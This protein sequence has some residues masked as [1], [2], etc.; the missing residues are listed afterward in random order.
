MA[1]EV[2]NQRY[3]SAK[4]A[5][6]DT[7]Y[8]RMNSCQRDA[9]YTVNGPLLVLAGAGSGKTTVLVNRISH[10]IRYGN[11]Y[12]SESVPSDI[13]EAEI[14]R[15]EAM[16]SLD[17]EALA[18]ALS[19]FADAPCPPWAVLAITFT[20]KAAGEIKERLE[21]V[22]GDPDAA[23]EI[24]AGTFHSICVRILRRYAQ[25][26]GYES[27]FTIYDT[28]DTKKLITSCMK[29]LGIDEKVIAP[30]AAMSVISRAKDKLMT[31]KEFSAEAA[32]DFKLSRIAQIYLE[33]ERELKSANALDFDDII[34]QTVLLLMAN[35]EVR[36]YYQNRFRYVCVDE[37][38]DT[39]I[40]QLKLCEL[41]SAKR[42]NIMV[43]GD[44]DQSIY[45][46][47]GATIENILTFDRAFSDCKVI[48]L[49][50]NYRSTA[51][52]LNAANAVIANNKG[53][54]GKSLW[55]D[56]GDGDK[57]TV[58]QLPNQNIEAQYVAD[59]ILESVRRDG[60]RFS[61]FAVLYRMN[62]QSAPLESVFTK[63]GI[64][65]RMLGGLRFFDRKEIKDIVAYLCVISNS[66]DS[67][68]LK[69]I[70]NEPKRKIG[71]STVGA[72][73]ALAAIENT[74]LYDI[75]KRSNQYMQLTK[76]CDRLLAFTD[77]IDRMRSLSQ[78]VTI[79]EL[80]NT[81]V[82]ESGYH[83]MLLEEGET[84]IE[85]LRN[86]DE[87]IAS[88]ASYDE[89]AD[90]P[91]LSGFLEEVALVSDTDNYD[92][93][94][95]AV[96]MMTIHSAKGLEF[97]TVFLPGLEEGI[98]PGT[99]SIGNDEEIEEERRLAYVAITRAKKKLYILNA[100]ERMMFGKTRY[101]PPSCFLTEIPPQYINNETEGSREP[102]NIMHTRYKPELSKEM[103]TPVTSSSPIKRTPLEIFS[104][105][106]RVVHA[107][108]G[109][110]TR[111][112][113][114]KM[115]DDTLYE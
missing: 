25:L 48:K 84:G 37:F 96:V 52:I 36:T 77:F 110:G 113:V 62:S 28:D 19:E 57:I 32:S 29:R 10:I 105:G 112:S 99:M 44:D 41:I 111:L 75:M 6:F 81:V 68:R 11:A 46:F 60:L 64:P 4:R 115:G 7:Y 8:N 114:K 51:N 109:E 2:L 101:N 20:N 21:K 63:S 55:T 43:V 34:M 93:Q 26:A 13:T 39:N 78:A 40:A 94:A 17:S 5:L 90:D 1:N 88:A 14:E 100:R 12:Y 61:D 33:Y 102:V 15:I 95:D 38:Q 80:I 73:E 106:E 35:E 72:V 76:V 86:I 18:E 91:T 42:K 27:S 70:I 69:R 16:R 49:E 87:L 53:R 92:A 45:K 66:R 82:E 104:E 97:P 23:K 58:K 22:I 108:F 67:V 83:D 30:R 59:R 47:R 50:Q 65:Y 107:T 31:A 3:I 79:G 54:K 56:G 24:W 74:D 9:V 89:S 103:T 98:F 71:D 85:R